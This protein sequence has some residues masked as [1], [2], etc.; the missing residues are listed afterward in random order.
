MFH[1]LSLNINEIK[2]SLD[3][4]KIEEKIFEIND[5]ILNCENAYILEHLTD[6]ALFKFFRICNSEIIRREL[7]DSNR[8]K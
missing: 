5:Q 2:G 8:N 3:L 7:N 4:E 6:E 1:K